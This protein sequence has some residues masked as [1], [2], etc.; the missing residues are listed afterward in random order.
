MANIVSAEVP[1]SV[2]EAQID[3]FQQ[4]DQ[5]GLGL[6]IIAFLCLIITNAARNLKA[7][8]TTSIVFKQRF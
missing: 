5:I 2:L 3:L 7:L 4:S 1:F 8:I 6:S